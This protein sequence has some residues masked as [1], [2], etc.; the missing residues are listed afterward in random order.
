M[1][2]YHEVYIVEKS[3]VV[4]CHED[5]VQCW[6]CMEQT[7]VVLLIFWEIWCLDIH[8]Q[9]IELVVWVWIHS[10]CCVPELDGL[11]LNFAIS[12]YAKTVRLSG[13]NLIAKYQPKYWWIFVTSVLRRGLIFVALCFSLGNLLCFVNNNIGVN[14]Y[15]D[16]WWHYCS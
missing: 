5:C 10:L 3:S 2:H 9:L 11:L 15:T 4:H 1:V 6:T 12:N 13:A 8:C 14:C 7:S 16:I